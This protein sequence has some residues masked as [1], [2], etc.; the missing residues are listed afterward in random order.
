MN[1]KEIAIIVGVVVAGIAS[2]ISLFYFADKQPV[3]KMDRVQ[4]TIEIDKC[5]SKTNF[6]SDKIFDCAIE[7]EEAAQYCVANCEYINV[8][9]PSR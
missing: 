8:Q 2:Y 9:V 3:I 7:A 4:F 5:L 1:W 6:H